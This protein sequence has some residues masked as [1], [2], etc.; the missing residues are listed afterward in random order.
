MSYVKI[1]FIRRPLVR[2]TLMDACEDYTFSVHSQYPGKIVEGKKGSE[3]T[4]DP[5]KFH[6]ALS[7]LTALSMRELFHWLPYAR[8]KFVLELVRIT[9]RLRNS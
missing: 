7:N 8:E 3:E 1:S 5:I 4:G 9:L 6:L 2:E